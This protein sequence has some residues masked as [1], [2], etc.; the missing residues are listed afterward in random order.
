MRALTVNEIGYVGGGV[1][2]LPVT[3]E[4]V[5]TGR[6]IVDWWDPVTYLYMQRDFLGQGRSNQIGR[7]TAIARPINLVG[8]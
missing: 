6:R 2:N 7:N 4:V 3:D 8:F 1:E 5:I